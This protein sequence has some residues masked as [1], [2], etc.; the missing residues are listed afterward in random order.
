MAQIPG[1]PTPQRSRV[2]ATNDIYTVLVGIALFTV[3][4]TMAFAIYRCVDLLGTPF[5]GFQ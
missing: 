1:S 3:L 2:A 4:G 5:P